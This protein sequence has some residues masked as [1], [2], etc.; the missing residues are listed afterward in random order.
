M[1]PMAGDGT[2]LPLVP[3]TSVVHFPRTELKLHVVDPSYSQLVHDLE[4]LDEGS[5]WMGVVLMKPG[6]QLDA[7]GAPRSSPAAPPPG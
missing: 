2:R 3:L 1:D 4:A 7:G 5:R 6:P